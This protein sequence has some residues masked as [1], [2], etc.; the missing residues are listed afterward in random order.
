MSCQHLTAVRH[1]NIMKADSTGQCN[2]SLKIWAGVLKPNVLRGLAFNFAAM[3]LNW[4]WVYIASPLPLGKYCLMIKLDDDPAIPESTIARL[5]WTY[6]PLLERSH[7]RQPRNLPKLMSTVAFFQEVVAAV[8]RP[9]G[10][11]NSEQKEPTAIEQQIAS[12]AYSLLQSWKQLP[13]ATGNSV[14]G[15]ALQS[16]VNAARAACK[17][18]G[19][20]F[21]MAQFRRSDERRMTIYS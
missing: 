16:W 21:H 12:Q 5:E 4:L 10:D 19:L 8:Y 2:A 14:D 9:E 17:L 11:D 15:K 13:G 7:T 18:S 20:G 1:Q 6:L 3:A